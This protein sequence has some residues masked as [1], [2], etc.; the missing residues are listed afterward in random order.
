M[1]TGELVDLIKASANLAWPIIVVIVLIALFP[2]IKKI[3]ESRSFSLEIAGMKVSVQ[4][5]AEQLRAQIEDLQRQVIALRDQSGPKLTVREA[6]RD[7]GDD[8]D[9]DAADAAAAPA[10]PAATPPAPAPPRSSTQRVLWVDDNM[11]NN[12][13][14]IAQLKDQG[15]TVV[16]SAST[17][18]AMRILHSSPPFD[19]V[20]SDMGRREAGRYDSGAGLSL[21]QRMRAEHIA[22]AFIVYTTRD[23]AQR[24]AA[25]VRAAGGSGATGSAVELLEWVHERVGG[26]PAA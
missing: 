18:D 2:G 7:A 23:F 17:E 16:Q 26:A 3:I 21:L 9:E 24:T 13:F 20:I 25:A 4:D 15:V 10:A 19:A 12:A 6:D 1:K 11:S 22:T 14:Q 5:A 8:E